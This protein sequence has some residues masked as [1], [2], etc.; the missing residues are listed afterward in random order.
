MAERTVTSPFNGNDEPQNVREYGDKL[1]YR[2]PEM[3]RG[4]GDTD[5][6]TR[7]ER[8]EAEDVFSRVEIRGDGGA[9]VLTREML[10]KEGL[11]PEHRMEIEDR[12]IWFS[13]GFDAGNGYTAVIGYVTDDEGKV[14]ARSY[15]RSNS[16]GVWRYL[17]QYTTN[18]YDEL[19]WYSKGYGEE[20]YTA[21]STSR[22]TCSFA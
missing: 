14:V 4:M 5:V 20:R 9:G 15:Y 10:E 18:D 17:P 1:A 13:P 8:D 22:R 3:E 7:I 6:I 19:D 11:L 16:Q 21:R 12:V 2:P